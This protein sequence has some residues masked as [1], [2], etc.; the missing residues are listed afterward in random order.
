MFLVL[1]DLSTVFGRVDHTRLLSFLLQAYGITG[2]QCMES[3]LR[4]KLEAVTINGADSHNRLL[5]YGVHQGSFLG[6]ELF[7][8]YVAPLVDM[9]QSYDVEFNEY[10]DD[11]HLYVSFKSGADED[12]GLKQIQECIA[13]VKTWM[14]RNW[15]KLN[16]DKTEFIVL[17]SL[18]NLAN[19]Y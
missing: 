7:K 14:E 13:A 2:L 10:A 8:D 17:V 11:M 3:Y 4:N 5:E 1:L 16:D 6:P 15:L 19:W 12:K 9:I 18:A